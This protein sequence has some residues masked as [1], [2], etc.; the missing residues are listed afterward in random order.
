MAGYSLHKFREAQ[1]QT[2]C[3][4]INKAMHF[5]Q[6]KARN[7]AWLEK[8]QCFAEV[9]VCWTKFRTEEPIRISCRSRYSRRKLV[10]QTTFPNNVAKSHHFPDMRLLHAM[11]FI[12]MK[13]D[14]SNAKAVYRAILSAMDFVDD[15]HNQRIHTV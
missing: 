9:H 5:S 3:W 14:V 13:N 2:V 15:V 12:T 11:G 1:G 8:R 7:A 6:S 4:N 10:Q